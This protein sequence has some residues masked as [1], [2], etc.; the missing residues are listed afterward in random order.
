[1]RLKL[2]VAYKLLVESAANGSQLRLSELSNLVKVEPDLLAEILGR[3][4]AISIVGDEIRVTDVPRLILEAWRDGFSLVEVALSAG[5]RD[6]EDLCELMLSERGY[7]TFK[8]LRILSL[9][10]I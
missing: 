10:H 8:H 9:I 3:S 6:V 7:R 2:Q 5:W 1:M 4:K